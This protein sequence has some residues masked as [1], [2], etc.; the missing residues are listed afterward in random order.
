MRQWTAFAC[1]FLAAATVGAQAPRKSSTA[2]GEWPTYGGDLASS[3]YSP[4]E[5]ITA[6]NFAALKIAWRTPSPDGVLTMTM[7]GGGEWTNVCNCDTV[8]SQFSNPLAG[9][10]GGDVSDAPLV[11]QASFSGVV[12]DGP[13]GPGRD[14]AIGLSGAMLLGPAYQPTIPAPVDFPSVWNQQARK[15]HALHWD[16][17]SGSALERNVLV[18]VGAGTPRD[19]VP[20]ASINAIQT[21]LDA[22]LAPKYPFAI[23]QAQVPRG[24]QVFAERCASCHTEGGARTCN[25]SANVLDE[26]ACPVCRKESCQGDCQTSRVEPSRA[27]RFR[28]AADV[29]TDAP[30]VEVVERCVQDVQPS[31]VELGER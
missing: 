18:A 25:G 27:C 14:D 19:K 28:S 11:T 8:H 21:W 31:S 15:G 13:W 20:L 3:K 29:L 30:P 4:L 22:L 24:A 26:S 9:F 6:D 10:F 16:G 23:D 2:T 12:S 7:P 1:L 17:A 5:Q